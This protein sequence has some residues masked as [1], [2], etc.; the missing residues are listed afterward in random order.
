MK[1]KLRNMKYQRAHFES[2][3][4]QKIDESLKALLM[5]E[6]VMLRER[7]PRPGNIMDP[8][9]VSSVIKAVLSDKHLVA[10]ENDPQTLD[11]RLLAVDSRLKPVN[12]IGLFRKFLVAEKAD[13]ALISVAG[14]LE[15]KD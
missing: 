14:Y 4:N 2:N 7:N 8:I 13:P 6:R 12:Y 5:N 9:E 10:E 3:N 11:N 15:L 1:Y